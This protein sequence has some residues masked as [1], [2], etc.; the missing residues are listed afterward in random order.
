MASMLYFL[1]QKLVF[2]IDAWERITNHV[3][4][5]YYVPELKK[6]H[7]DNNAQCHLLRSISAGWLLSLDCRFFFLLDLEQCLQAKIY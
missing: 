5:P 7:K 6:M 1:N 4:T 2:V 3:A